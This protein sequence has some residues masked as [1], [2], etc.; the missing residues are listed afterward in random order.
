PPA[1]FYSYY[2]YL[3]KVDADCKVYEL[4]LTFSYNFGRTKQ[5]HWFASAG[6]SS[7]LMKTEA[8]NYF[9]K[10]SPLGPTVN[11]KWGIENKNKH[12]FSVLGISAGYQRNLSKSLSIIAEP[13]LKLPMSGVGYGKVK[14]N[15]A[16]LLFSI[17]V[18]PFSFS[19]KNKPL[20]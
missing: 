8:Y 7:Y 6:I 19:K 16:G 9:Y 4:P 2:P 15:S 11:R 14:L 18:K 3:E 1:V 5:Q 10:T 13:Y 12:L 20:P 17:A